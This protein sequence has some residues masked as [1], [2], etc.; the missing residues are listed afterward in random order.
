[1]PYLC[2]LWRFANA[3]I[4]K[5]RKGFIMA[6]AKYTRQKNGYFQT[7]V[8][9]GIYN[10][11]GTKHLVNLRTNKSSK[12][13]EN[14]VNEMKQKVQNREFVQSTDM[15]FLTYARDWCKIYKSQTTLNT[16]KMYQNIIEKH[17][18]CVI[19]HINEVNRSHY[20]LTLNNIEGART[21]QQ[22][23]MTF[24]QIMKATIPL[25]D[26]TPKERAFVY[27]LFGYGL[28]RGEALALTRFDISLDKKEISINKARV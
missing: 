24:K 20:L 27:I 10:P 22:A 2:G 3:Y 12:E 8:W 26:F 25:A 18:S 14:M 15:L 19:C 17:L 1:M 4:P 13:L 28:R 21:K 23:A 9:D 11:Y 6:K 16:Q 7:K 5:N